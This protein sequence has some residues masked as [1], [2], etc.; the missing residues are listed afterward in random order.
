MIEITR[1]YSKK[2]IKLILRNT[3]KEDMD[4]LMTDEILVVNGKLVEHKILTEHQ[5]LI[6]GWQKR[7]KELRS[8]YLG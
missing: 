1:N 5:E 3:W 6:L 4:I 8:K 2:Y 7:I